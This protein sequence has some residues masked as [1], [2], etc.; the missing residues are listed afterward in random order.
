MNSAAWTPSPRFRLW[1]AGSG[2]PELQREFRRVM[3][4]TQDKNASLRRNRW[5]STSQTRAHDRARKCL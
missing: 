2:A 3:E 4:G 1:I 5:R